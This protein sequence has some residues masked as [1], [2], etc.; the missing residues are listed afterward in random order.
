MAAKTKTPTTSDAQKAVAAAESDLARWEKALAEANVALLTVRGTKPKSPAEA[1]TLASDRSTAEN[2]VAILGEAVAEAE[3]AVTAA[4]ADVL[5][6]LATEEDQRA[7]AANAQCD[8]AR[9]KIAAL[10][11]DL[12]TAKAVLAK[13]LGEASLADTRAKVHRYAAANQQVPDGLTAYEAGIG[14]TF[15]RLQVSGAEVIPPEAREFAGQ[16]APEVVDDAPYVNG[17]KR[18]GVGWEGAP[19]DDAATVL[20]TGERTQSL[21]PE[22]AHLDRD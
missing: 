21:D 19:D 12:K 20:T 8:S 17:S 22:T 16:F 1:D 9:T 11:G 3:L 18:Y 2:R 14:D 13:A 10:E 5:L 7:A 15:A 4:K 6:A